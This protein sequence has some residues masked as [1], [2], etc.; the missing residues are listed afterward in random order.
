LTD[1]PT[2]DDLERFARGNLPRAAAGE[3]LRHLLRGCR[4]CMERLPSP[5]VA[6]PAD[7]PAPG[8][9]SSGSEYGAPIARALAAVLS[10]K[11]R[12]RGDEWVRVERGLELLRSKP[13]GVF[14][15]TDE[16]AEELRGVPFV[17][18]LVQLSSDERYRNPTQMLSLAI[19][20]RTAADNLDL[21]DY[22]P[23]VIADHQA[24]AWGELGNAYR[25]SDELGQAR[26]ALAAAERYRRQGT[27]N[28]LLLA[29]LADLQASLFSSQRLL[30][31]ACELLDG[32]HRLYLKVGDDHLA[33]RALVK[34]SIYTDYG[35]DPVRALRLL[36]QGLELLDRDRDPQLATSAT[37]N[38]LELMVRCGE[39]REA[40]RMLLESGLRKA[41]AD[42][43]L[44]LL[45]LRWVEGQI[46]AG[47][48][49]L[50]R[51]ESAL[52]EARDGFLAHNLGYRAAIAGLDLAAVRLEQ[53]KNEQVEELA[54]DMLATFRRLG[55]QREA[56]RA[57]DYLEKACQRRRA[58]PGLARHVGRFLRQLEREPQLRF[59]AL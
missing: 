51:A 47:L 3:V 35:G 54:R 37:E 10:G 13:R 28:L 50:G 46:L 36:R 2:G 14:D 45:K 21:A 57:L 24:R 53:G 44:N 29:R 40:A 33:G 34:R 12:R 1:H 58:T 43:P 15:L 31:D 16:E 22:S 56:V 49:K 41:L 20:A 19:L 52:Q 42:Q 30:P 32:V 26:A 5:A 7:L 55:I 8:Q 9:A 18:V 17:E 4:T 6:D 59:E 38:V 48:G 11:P 39:F 23:E 27:G 25:V